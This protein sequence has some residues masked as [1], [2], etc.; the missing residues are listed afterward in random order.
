VLGTVLGEILG[1][2]L[3]E[4]LGD[5][6]GVVLG[7][8][9]GEVLGGE[10]GEALGEVLG[11]LLGVELGAGLRVGAPVGSFV[12]INGAKAMGPG[13]LEES[14]HTFKLDTAPIPLKW[15]VN[16]ATSS[17]PTFTSIVLPDVEGTGV[18][19]TVPLSVVAY[20][21]APFW[22]LNNSISIT[23]STLGS[24]VK[25]MFPP[26]G[27]ETGVFTFVAW[28]IRTVPRVSLSNDVS[29]SFVVSA[30]L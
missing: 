3:G 9:L 16:S 12:P 18:S 20:T 11:L 30:T 24:N 17:T 26:S 5:L 19:V 1:V 27:F 29:M 28:I 2:V 21:V 23:S 14:R 22:I 4:V 10:L 25:V 8:V 7:Y 6:L 13:V 15:T